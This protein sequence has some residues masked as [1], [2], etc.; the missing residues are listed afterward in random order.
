MA[1][2]GGTNRRY[3]AAMSETEGTLRRDRI[4][5]WAPLAIVAAVPLAVLPGAQ[6]PFHPLKWLL[7]LALVPAGLAATARWGRLRLP[8]ARWWL[9]WLAVLLLTTVIG[10]APWVSVAGAP[11]R[12]AGLLSWLVAVGAFALGASTGAVPVVLR[13]VVRG[14]FLSGALVAASV[15]MERAGVDLFGIGVRGIARGRGTWGSATF[16]AGHLA[17]VAPLAVA[18]LRA[19]DVRWRRVGAG[20]A[21]V[22]GVG[23]VLTGTRGAWLGAAAAALVL[24]PLYREQLRRVA[25][26]ARAVIGA[27]LLLALVVAVT[28]GLARGSAVGRLDQW[29]GSLGAVA[30]RPLFGSGPDTQRI[31]LPAEIDEAFERRHGSEELH[32]RAHNLLLDTWVTSGLAGVLAL[33][34]LLLAIGRRLRAGIGDQLMPRAVAAGLLAYLVHLLFAFGEPTL[35][36]VA[37]LLAGL[38]FAAIER[39]ATATATAARAEEPAARPTDAMRPGVGV[40]TS[41]R[42]RVLLTV[43]LVIVTALTLIWGGGEAVADRKLDRALRE[44][45][46]GDRV[47]ALR[48]LH[49]AIRLAPAR[50]DLR[51]VRARVTTELLTSGSPATSGYDPRSEPLVLRRLVGDARHD[52]DRAEAF[53]PGDPDIGLDRGALLVEIDD[54]VGARR[55]YRSVLA[56]YPNSSRAWLGLGVVEAEAGHTEAAV[57]HWKHAAAL[58]PGDA[59]PR[60]DLGLMYEITGHPVKSLAAFRE[61][62]A[63]EPDNATAQASVERLEQRVKA[64]PSD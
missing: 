23:L 59:R 62:L 28:P 10:V 63:I 27:I 2:N 29:R 36:P 56:G 45:E 17:L 57:A 34:A 4:L 7:V 16:A 26:P 64:L 6:S 25:R 5:S 32:D 52:L 13:R 40:A 31:V 14:A 33:G 58:A 1:P 42:T 24:A 55:A 53:A 22:M 46:N 41:P 11:Q 8:L 19:A 51:Q 54:L 12:N 9:L 18:H 60:I 39:S 61:A 48:T 50:Y 3:G 49:D 20:S 43:A 21:V 47:G 30:E 37:W 44:A 15:V 38:T 35:D